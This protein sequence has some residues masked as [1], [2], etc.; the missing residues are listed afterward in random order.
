MALAIGLPAATRQSAAEQP[1]NPPGGAIVAACTAQADAPWSKPVNGLQARIFLKRTEVFQGTPIIATFL[2]LR[3]VSNVMNP[4]R[5]AWT[6]RGMKLRVLDSKGREVTPGPVA[7]SGP[8]VDKLDLLL[9][10]RST[11]A[12]DVSEGGWGVFADKAGQLETW[13]FERDD[14]DYYLHAVL[15]VAE[16]RRA[17][18]G[19]TLPWHGK[20]EIPRVLVPL[21]P[22]KLDPATLGPLIEKLGRKMFSGDCDVSQ[23]AVR[24]L[25]LVDDPRVVPWYVKAMDTDQYDL[26]FAA[27]DRLARFNSDAAI[28]GIKQGMRPQK[29][30]RDKDVIRH[31]AASALLRSPHPQA[32]KLLL[33]MRDDPYREVRVIVVEALGKMHDKESLDL[34]EKLSHDADKGVREQAA[35]CLESRTKK[36]ETPRN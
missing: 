2:E 10:L 6:R 5:V 27:L 31:L 33:T 11:L 34:L 15:E 24:A 23:E 18:D 4:M 1:L 35:E 17:R 12:F 21:K 14:Q 36:P 30:E 28:E 22:E 25:S 16:G 9:P 26:K 19:F 32:K 3:N 29:D 7:H 13:T 8:V 20:L